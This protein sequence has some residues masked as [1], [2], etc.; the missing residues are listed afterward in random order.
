M[1]KYLLQISQIMDDLRSAT[2]T[3]DSSEEEAGKAL[4]G[5][6]MQGASASDSFETS[7]VKAIQFAVS[8]LHIT[9]QKA[10][11]I[12]KR[13]IKKLLEK[14]GDGEATKK[15]ILKYLLY[16]LKKYGNLV[17]GDQSGNTCVHHEA[18]V[19][20][21]NR[22]KNSMYSQSV[23]AEL[24]VGYGH[25]EAQI[26]VLSRAVPPEEFR[27]P[28]SSRLMYDP[29]VIESGQT[30]ERMWIQK[31]FAEGN[32]TCPRTKVKLTHLSLTPNT[33][34]KDLISKWCMRYGV[35]IPDPTMKP[36][37]HYNLEISSSSIVSFS[38]SMNDL[39]LQLDLS[40]MSIGSLDMSYTSD[41]SH[42]KIADGLSLMSMQT[43]DEHKCQSS[44]NINDS[45]LKFLFKLAEL[46]WESQCEVVEDVK[47]KLNYNEEACHAMS[48][49]NFVEPLVRFLK[50]ACDRNDIKAQKS[51]SQLLLAFVS[52]NR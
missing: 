45:D 16:L 40:N 4:R 15:K 37:V 32:D 31:W 10:I 13:S 7:E 5:L 51:G 3:L 21:E 41:S 52:K 46:E 9:S 19:A 50:D 34:M 36:E 14:V 24:H 33:S 38:S 42:N 25:H 49:E 47:K 22:R 20:S 1:M 6:L 12:E 29:V 18:A 28:I 35:T 43:R 44:A 39:Q 26:D 27:C 2:F 30:F 48:S 11:L 8:T 23:E 17:L